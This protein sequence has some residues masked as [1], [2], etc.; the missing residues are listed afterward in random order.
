MG[1]TFAAVLLF[2]AAVASLLVIGAE[3]HRPAQQPPAVGHLLALKSR[4]ARWQHDVG[5]RTSP[6]RRRQSRAPQLSALNAA[7]AQHRNPAK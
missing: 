4:R 5:A 1:V 2:A 6:T 3:P 7:Y